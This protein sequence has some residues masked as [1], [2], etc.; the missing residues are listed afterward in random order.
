MIAATSG[1]P[2]F[3]LG[4]DSAPHSKERK[5]SA[6]GCAGIYTAHAALELYAT[7]FERADALNKLE[8]FASHHGA[9]FY[10]LPRNEDTI[11]LTKTDWH[12]PESYSLGDSTV[13]PMFAGEIALVTGAASGIGKACVE[14]LLERGAAVIGLD[15]NGA[16]VGVFNR[17]DFLGIACDVTD[18]G[19]L[20]AALEQGVRRFGGLDMLVLNAGVFPGGCAIA[21]LDLAQWNR[22]MTVNLDANLSLMRESYP[23]LKRAPNYGRVVVVGSKNVPAPGP[24]AAA[25]SASKSALNQLARVAALEWGTDGIRVNTLHPDA[26]FDTGIWTDDVIASRAKHYGVS[27]DEYKTKNILKTEI[28]SRDVAQLVVE[29]CSLV[30][31]KTTGAQI[32]IDG[33]NERVI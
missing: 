13:V 19:Q 21:E 30:F 2:K 33:G 1:S 8:G 20:S 6:C 14:A 26:V 9:D 4:T 7:A 3:F 10:G 29:L 28:G 17:P 23:L 12:V 27:V 31:A 22:V 32:P 18:E 5:E 11:T 15:I 16:I 24:G 25:Y